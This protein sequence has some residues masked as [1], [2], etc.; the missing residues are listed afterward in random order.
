MGSCVRRDP[1]KEAVELHKSF[2]DPNHHLAKKLPDYWRRVRELEAEITEHLRPR[3]LTDPDNQRLL[4]EV[5]R[6]HD[7]AIAL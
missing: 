1:L 3:K 4:N 5:G 7:R 2:H 6:H